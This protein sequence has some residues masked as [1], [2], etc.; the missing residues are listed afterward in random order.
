MPAFWLCPHSVRSRV[1]ATVGCPSVRPVRPP[2][3]AGL[4]LW[5]RWWSST[6]RLLHSWQ[7]AAGECRQFHVSVH[8]SWT[9]TCYLCVLT[10]S[11]DYLIQT[12]RLTVKCIAYKQCPVS[13]FL[14]GCNSF[15]HASCGGY[16]VLTILITCQ[17]PCH[18]FVIVFDKIQV[19]IHK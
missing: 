10:D 3:A 11:D 4:L 17:K 5:V 14:C 8:S 2:H 9:Q 13:Y 15:V 16:F 6:N 18:R 12:V 7:A 19:Y 1:C